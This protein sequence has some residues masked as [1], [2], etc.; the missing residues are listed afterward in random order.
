MAE[1]GQTISRIRELEVRYKSHRL[2]APFSKVLAEPR[3]VAALSFEILQD[4]AQE[5]VLVLHLDVRRGVI[6]YHRIPGTLDHVDVS[7]ADIIRAALLSNAHGLVFVHNHVS[8]DPRPSDDDRQSIQRLRNATRILGL[9]LV[10]AVI[11]GD[12]ESTPS[13]YSFKDNQQL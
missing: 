1:T 12:P 5:A 2:R 9:D 11:L 13:F 6:G 3:A 7:V 8:G 4:I 10:D